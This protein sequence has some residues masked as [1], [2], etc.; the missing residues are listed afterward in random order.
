MNNKEQGETSGKP[1]PAYNI[2]EVPAYELATSTLKPTL[3]SVGGN[4]IY[5]SVKH[6][7]ELD[8]YEVSTNEQTHEQEPYLATNN[9]DRDLSNSSL[10]LF[11]TNILPSTNNKFNTPEE[12]NIIQ[13]YKQ[14]FFDFNSIPIYPYPNEN[15]DIL[16]A[17]QQQQ[18]QL[19]K[20]Q[21]EKLQ[22]LE[23]QEQQQRKDREQQKQ[24]EREREQQEQREREQKEQRDQKELEQKL[25]LNKLRAEQVLEQQASMAQQKPPRVKDLPMS[26][27]V[28]ET[29]PPSSQ[30]SAPTNLT[31]LTTIVVNEPSQS[32]KPKV[33]SHTQKPLAVQ[34]VYEEVTTETTTHTTELFTKEVLTEVHD[35][36][37]G[38]LIH[39]INETEY[40]TAD[41]QEPEEDDDND[42]EELDRQRRE[43]AGNYSDSLVFNALYDKS[44]GEKR[45]EHKSNSLSSTSVAT[46]TYKINSL[47]IS[48][49]LKH[50]LTNQEKVP[51]EEEEEEKE[52]KVNILDEKQQHVQ[53]N[54][55]NY[56][57]KT[58][59]FEKNL[60]KEQLENNKQ[61]TLAQIIEAL[62]REKSHLLSI[63][64]SNNSSNNNSDEA[65]ASISSANNNNSTCLT[66]AAPYAP[67]FQL[68]LRL[69]TKANPLDIGHH[70]IAHVEPESLAE[71]A[72]VRVHSKIIKLNETDCQDKTHEF[73][74]FYLNYLLRKNS[75]KSIEI[76][77]LEPPPP[78]VNSNNVEQMTVVVEENSNLKSIIKEVLFKAPETLSPL[79]PPLPESLLLPLPTPHH[80]PQAPLI[81]T[82]NMHQKEDPSQ[83]DLNT[84]NDN[85]FSELNSLSTFT[86]NNNSTREQVNQ[87]LKQIFQEALRI[88]Q[89]EHEQEPEQQPLKLSDDQLSLTSSNLLFNISDNIKEE[90]ANQGQELENLRDIVSEIK[91]STS[92]ISSPRP[93]SPLPTTATFTATT[94]NN[95]TIASF[96]YEQTKEQHHHS[97]PISFPAP[98]YEANHDIVH[99]ERESSNSSSPSHQQ[100]HHIMIQVNQDKHQH[101]QTASS[102][103]KLNV[104]NI[105]Y[106]SSSAYTVE[107]YATKNT[108]TKI[109]TN[110]TSEITS[111]QAQLHYDYYHIEREQRE[112]QLYQ[113][114]LLE[115]DTDLFVKGRTNSH[116]NKK[117]RKLTLNSHTV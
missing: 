9:I 19:E 115:S 104:Y 5:D 34:E 78:L 43:F 99:T 10:P 57:L 26:E 107:N 7:L 31:A 101:E 58:F 22:L 11:S 93:I 82:L 25:A 67:P 48:D 65:N 33:S 36:T 15:D 80:P 109:D 81:I 74:L 71:K 83:L 52:Q 111:N 116:N 112:N 96:Q 8:Q 39:D 100:P 56:V 97:T 20:E 37:T 24:L 30:T 91:S 110:A 46:S 13:D 77:V 95:T 60:T 2:K 53:E 73:T 35:P 3:A 105:V 51:T 85:S 61:P 12:T 55:K 106:D 21:R 62:N 18:Q 14:M 69:K 89:K 17:Q 79:P 41:I 44:L 72:G 40:G 66:S 47:P 84:S 117:T 50:L 68:G 76:T 64:A 108:T 54:E 88:H 114:E 86:N 103:D 42:E 90:E 92:S 4:V 29:A 94:V 102:S 45:H 98:P 38:E 28:S 49:E 87:Y 113:V 6:S 23:Q 63:N 1:K 27:I 16:K 32:E 70:V 75:C 59:L